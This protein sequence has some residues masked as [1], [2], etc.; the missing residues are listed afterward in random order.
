MIGLPV[1]ATL[2]ELP[3]L[4]AGDSPADR[5]IDK[6][7]GGYAEAIRGLQIGLAHSNV[8]KKAKVVLVTSSVP[9]EGKTTVAVSMA[10]LA[11]KSGQKV[12]LV[13]ADLR[14]PSVAET[15]G[16]SKPEKGILDVLTGTQ[17]VE[18][19]FM[20]DP[21]SPVMALLAT[22]AAG[23]PPDLLGSGA[24]EK[25]IDGLSKV[26]DMVVIDSAPLLP[27]HDT[28]VLSRLAD[29]IV[30]VVRWDKTPRDAVAMAARTLADTQT[31]VAGVALTRAD[32]T[33][34]KYYTYGYQ[35]YSAYNKYYND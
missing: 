8:D 3:G 11:A 14:H 13:D 22:K 4:K 23:N 20:R 12:V 19:S 15:L 2:P 9:S 28:R 21:K 24:M 1:L 33:R 35:D 17:S 32:E 7:M 16:V 25:L 5:V 29:A 18:G 31:R 26:F 34:Y 27:V 6:P 10:R 30:F